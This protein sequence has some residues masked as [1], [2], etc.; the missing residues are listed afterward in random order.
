MWCKAL[1]VYSS[2]FI[3]FTIGNWDTAHK[4][5][6][7]HAVLTFS[8]QRWRTCTIYLYLSGL[9]DN[10]KITFLTLIKWVG[11]CLGLKQWQGS[12]QW[13][14]YLETILPNKRTCWLTVKGISCPIISLFTCCWCGFFFH[15]KPFEP[16]IKLVLSAVLSRKF[17]CVA[18]SSIDSSGCHCFK[19]GWSKGTRGGLG[20][21]NTGFCS[22]TVGSLED[23]EGTDMAAFLWS[24]WPAS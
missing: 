24:C 22:Q 21:M 11:H 3:G 2:T 19:D 7:L 17:L 16:K 5:C 20:G 9:P 12:W 13:K 15:R 18:F 6:S 8:W 23:R 14:T 10:Q 1:Q 4:L